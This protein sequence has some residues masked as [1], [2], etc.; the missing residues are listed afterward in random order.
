MHG[1]DLQ[2]DPSLHGRVKTNRQES[3][4][5]TTMYIREELSPVEMVAIEDKPR[6]N[7]TQGSLSHV[8]HLARNAQLLRDETL[9]TAKM[10]LRTDVSDACYGLGRRVQH[11]RSVSVRGRKAGR[12]L[13]LA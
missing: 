9:T 11:R 12:T 7:R 4:L 13:P 1:P 3:M 5:C 10:G 8:V 6:L 2:F